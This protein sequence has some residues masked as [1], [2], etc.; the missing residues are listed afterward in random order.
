MK[1]DSLNEWGD[2]TVVV[3]CPSLLYD[4][5]AMIQNE[6]K[7][8]NR[9]GEGSNDIDCKTLSNSKFDLSLSEPEHKGSVS[10]WCSRST[11]VITAF[12]SS[13]YIIDSD[14]SSACL[15]CLVDIGKMT[16]WDSS[17]VS[18]LVLVN[19]EASV[20]WLSFIRGSI[21]VSVTTLDL[22]LEVESECFT[23][24]CAR[25]LFGADAFCTTHV[26]R[27]ADNDEE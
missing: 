13:C 11:T 10:C 23:Q 15:F 25:L 8:W 4:L 17:G 7:K 12:N 22:A 2:W 6:D 27:E 3:G 21:S 26:P 20:A 16:A 1:D 9:N 18:G 14:L 24:S 19:G 5:A